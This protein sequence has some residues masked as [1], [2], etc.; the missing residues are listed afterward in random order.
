[1]VWQIVSLPGVAGRIWLSQEEASLSRPS[2]FDRPGRTKAFA[3]SKA[4]ERTWKSSVGGRGRYGKLPVCLAV[5]TVEM[6]A[7][8]YVRGAGGGEF[9]QGVGLRKA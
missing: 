5:A 2:G 3:E 8:V 1:M 6:R 7:K 4:Q 9:W